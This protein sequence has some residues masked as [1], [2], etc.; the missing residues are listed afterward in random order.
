MSGNNRWGLL[1]HTSDAYPPPADNVVQVQA[2][3][4]YA[5][6]TGVDGR[7]AQATFDLHTFGADRRGLA[8]LA[9]SRD[10][11]HDRGQR[12]RRGRRRRCS[13]HD[14]DGRV[15]RGHAHAHAHALGEQPELHRAENRDRRGHGDLVRVLRR[16]VRHVAVRSCRR[17]VRGRDAR[18]DRAAPRA[19]HRG[20]GAYVLRDGRA[21]RTTRDPRS[22]RSKRTGP[23]IL[24]AAIRCT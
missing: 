6:A 14:A 9:R 10:L 2:G 19:H 22:S 16:R 13:A 1:V 21:H 5:V 23:G 8:D 20:P 15:R 4:A 11:R 3:S 18:S 12:D 7:G 17:R 24:T